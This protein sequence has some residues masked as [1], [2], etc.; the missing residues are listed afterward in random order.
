[1]AWDHIWEHFNNQPPLI[2]TLLVVKSSGRM[3]CFNAVQRFW[4]NKINFTDNEFMQELPIRILQPLKNRHSSNINTGNF[5]LVL[6]LFLLKTDHPS[7][8]TIWYGIK[9][10]GLWSHSCRHLRQWILSFFWWMTHIILC[11][12]MQ[13]TWFLGL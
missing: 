13:T 12:N 4:W 11:G 6:S 2:C 10:C 7:I 8:M 3:I 1:M 5:S 9:T